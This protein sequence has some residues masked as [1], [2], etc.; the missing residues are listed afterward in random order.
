MENAWFWGETF[1]LRRC[2]NSP[3]SRERDRTA[4]TRID[5]TPDAPTVRSEFTGSDEATHQ[6]D[7]RVW[8]PLRV[9]PQCSLAWEVAGEWCPSCGTA[10]DKSVREKQH[11]TRVM[12]HR[13]SETGGHRKAEPPP[14]RSA[15]S[16]R[17]AAAPAPKSVRQGPPVRR[18]PKQSSGTAR[19]VF[20]TVAVAA[21]I[22]AAF[23]VGQLSR[24]TDAQIDKSVNDAVSTARRS[25][26]ASYDKAFQKMQQRTQ[27]AIEDARQKGIAE[28][29]AALQAQAEAQKQDNQSIWDSVTRCVLGGD[30]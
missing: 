28:G 2:S 17:D 20:T 29:Q 8:A 14:K 9:C 10:F 13:V 19:V 21:A 4:H 15:R 3:M 5:E 23:F 27:K 26:A 11:A 16:T 1:L 25:A 22:V 12:P 18:E 24:P 30:C 7:P 6:I